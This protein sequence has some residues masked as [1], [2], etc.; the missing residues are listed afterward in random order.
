MNVPRARLVR[1]QMSLSEG[2]EE[3]PGEAVTGRQDG[4][5][6]GVAVGTLS[7][8]GVIDDSA[9]KW[10]KGALIKTGTLGAVYLGMDATENGNLIAVREIPLS[11]TTDFTSRKGLI[12]SLQREIEVL[13]AFQLERIIQYIATATS[14]T[15]FRIFMPY[16]PGGSIADLLANY[17]AFEESLAR[18][19]GR[20]VLEGVCFIHDHGMIHRDLKGGSILVDNHGGI[21]ISD[22]NVLKMVVQESL[23]TEPNAT[24]SLTSVFWSPP[25]VVIEKSYTT[26]SDVWSFGCFFMEMLTGSHPWPDLTPLQA[27][28]QIGSKKAPAFPQGLS[29]GAVDFIRETLQVGPKDRPSAQD[30]RRHSFICV[31]YKGGV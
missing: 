30:L 3:A 29:S 24:S 2:D 18:S 6:R 9:F 15:H 7:G 20:K 10:I 21:K 28:F 1:S 16:I 14:D 8:L 5:D 4:E 17:G 23:P 11:D 27:T 22:F 26:A 31:D 13:K 25:E 12:D 19:F